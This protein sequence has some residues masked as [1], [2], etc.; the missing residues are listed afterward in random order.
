MN[1][2]PIIATISKLVIPYIVMYALYIQ[3]AGENSPGGG[4]QAGA[5]F[6]TGLIALDMV[7]Y[8]NIHSGTMKNLLRISATG[9]IIYIAVGMYSIIFGANFLDYDLLWH[10]KPYGK[11]IGIFIVEISIG[12]T[13]VST[14]SLIYL[15]F[16]GREL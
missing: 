8:C 10:T 11:Q 3:I 9:I 7:K 13:V 4:F 14:L 2:N 5:I 15:A 6:A 1:N 16:K 12:F